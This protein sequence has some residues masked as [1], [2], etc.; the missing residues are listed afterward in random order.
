MIS[1]LK[2]SGVAILLL[3]FFLAG[4]FYL[5]S[6]HSKFVYDIN[7]HFVAYEKYG[8]AGFWSCW[9]ENTI[10][11][12]INCVNYVI[13]RLFG[14]SDIVWFTVF[15]FFHALCA[16]LL[17]RFLHYILQRIFFT[18]AFPA[19][20]ISMLLFLL[21]PFHS[22]TVVWGATLFYITFTASFLGIMLCF[23]RYAETPRPRYLVIL[24]LLY[25]FEMVTFEVFLIVAVLSVILYLLLQYTGS[26]SLTVRRLVTVF[27]LPQI[28]VIGL[29]FLW[30]QLRIGQIVGHYGAS[31]HFHYD[32]WLFTSNF[33]KYLLKFSYAHL[34]LSYHI[35]DKVYEHLSHHQVLIPILIFYILSVIAMVYN[36]FRRNTNPAWRIVILLFALFFITLLPVLNLLFQYNK[37]IEQERYMYVP[38]LFFYAGL[39][40]AFFQVF[41][42]AAYAFMLI[43]LCISVFFLHRNVYY[44]QENGKIFNSL[45]ADYR[46]PD[47]KR[48]FILLNGDNYRGAY[49]MRD[50]PESAFAEMLHVQR[51][52][53]IADNS[54]D[55]LQFNVLNPQ[56]SCY[57]E[58]VDSSTV[59]ITFAQWGNWF[60][61]KSYGAASYDSTLYKVTIDEWNHSFTAQFKDKQPGDVYIYQA[62]D[63]WVEVRGF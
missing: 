29:Y 51:H 6:L 8:I 46:W 63:K 14:A 43:A 22:E 52:I 36:F 47:A 50:M 48:I 2:N 20:F 23:V 12:G 37:D 13:W 3:N 28:A 30:N 18:Y 5:P 58:I 25:L 33:T 1:R 62:K 9:G 45:I 39:T 61:Y 35:R 40:I 49:M 4:L 54:Y 59:K 16:T 10:R 38:A 17:Y 31:T 19:A 42:R 11:W 24:Y 55:L 15:I 21:S 26:L 44:W 7:M 53:D 60:W 32:T 56:D 34:F 27:V 57:H 41:R